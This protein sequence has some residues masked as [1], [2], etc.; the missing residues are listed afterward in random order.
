MASTWIMRGSIRRRRDLPGSPACAPSSAPL[1]VPRLLPSSP[2]SP[3]RSAPRRRPIRWSTPTRSSRAIPRPARWASPC[4]R[5]GS[6]SA[7]SS[8]GREAGVGVVATQSLVDPAYGPKGLD[9]MR[10]GVPAPKALEQLVAADAGRER[11]PGRDARRHRRGRTPTPD[12]APSPRPGHHVGAQYSVQANMMGK[13]TV[14]PAMA[15]AFEA[16]K[17]TLADRLIAALEAAEGE[18]GDVRG[19][20]SA[21]LLIVKAKGT[22]QAVGRRRPP[23]RPARGRPPAAGR[24][25]EAPGAP[26]ERLHARQPR[27]R[28]DDREEGRGGAEG[29]RRVGADRARDRR[30]AVL[31]G[32]DA[33][34][35]R[36]G[37]RSQR[38]SS[39]R[40][41]PRS[42]SGP[43]SW[44]GC[45]P[46]GSSPT[47]RR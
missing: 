34:L 21:A 30:A 31:A 39:R 24:R 27:R 6:P 26:A 19:R 3:S 35:D 11:P 42:R 13:P 46:P 23:L 2:S 15:K 20:Q 5:T 47:T 25:A 36:Q 38:R 37:S 12:P 14:W 44:P 16:A 32:G 45:R 41:S 1:S 18:G 40:S 33:G 28:A 29:V 10:Q 4:S 9:L 22:R 43:S 17:G 7:R 8:R